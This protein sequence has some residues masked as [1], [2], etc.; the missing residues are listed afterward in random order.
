MNPAAPER[1][2]HH[3][4]SGWR[5]EREYLE[6]YQQD[7]GEAEYFAHVEGA[8]HNYPLGP[9]ETILVG[10]EPINWKAKIPF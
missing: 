8:T 2:L 5:S 7:K 9:T 3:T 1:N 10:N 4:M 6:E